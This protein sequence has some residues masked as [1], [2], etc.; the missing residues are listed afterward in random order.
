VLPS[1]PLIDTEKR[2]IPG[3]NSFRSDSRFTF[4]LNT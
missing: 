3:L 1:A 2:L 4:A